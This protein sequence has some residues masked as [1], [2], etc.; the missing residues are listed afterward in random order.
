MINSAQIL[1]A[2]GGVALAG[3]IVAGAILLSKRNKLN[4][5]KTVPL[6]LPEKFTCTAHT[7]CM[8]TADNSLDCFDAAVKNGADVV[9]FDLNFTADG[10]PVL[11]HDKPQG[12]EVTLDE[13]FCKL[14]ELKNLFVNVDVKSTLNLAEVERL[15]EKHGISDRIFYTGVTE[16]FL[17]A[18]RADS[19]NVS[20]YLNVKVDRR[21]DDEYINSLVEK[22]RNCGAV[23]INFNK[24]NASEKLV[25]A[26]HKNG[27]LVSVWTA[28]KEIDIRRLLALSPDNITTKRPDLMTKIIK[29][30]SK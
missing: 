4:R 29:D 22:V 17:E 20:Y 24:K 12:N 27:L 3:A 5:Y 13:A 7:G 19:P 1:A 14:S 30:C 23:G 15:A 11:S 18:V 9:E 2:A 6:D 21:T 16:D 26:F 10:K 28:N 8:G 25:D